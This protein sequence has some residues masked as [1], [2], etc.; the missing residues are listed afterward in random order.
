MPASRAWVTSR[1]ISAAAG[2]AASGGSS[3]PVRRTPIR[4]LISDRACRPMSADL[5][6]GLARPFGCGVERVSAPV[7]LRHHHAEVVGDNVVQLPGDAGTL[8]RR[9]DLRLGISLPFGPD[10]ALFH[11]GKAGAPVRHRSPSTHAV[12]GA[13][14]VDHAGHESERQQVRSARQV[15]E[16]HRVTAAANTTMQAARRAA[17][18]AWAG[19]RDG[20]QQHQDP[21]VG[22]RRLQRAVG[23]GQPDADDYLG[24]TDG[25]R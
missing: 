21:G 19:G 1:A 3:G 4:L 9:G 16:F 17:R 2:A 13:I 11:P 14:N 5:C 15:R 18:S 10:G 20:V 23:E 12:T 8:G 25:Q 24:D 6:Q 7:G 22:E